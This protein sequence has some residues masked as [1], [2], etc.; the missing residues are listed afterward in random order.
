MKDLPVIYFISDQVINMI[1]TDKYLLN[2]QGKKCFLRKTS[3]NYYVLQ[4]QFSVLEC[5][6]A[7]RVL[8]GVEISILVLEG[9]GGRIIKWFIIGTER[10]GLKNF[11]RSKG[12]NCYC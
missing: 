10:T 8:C 1:K 3:E 7:T 6:A 4:R 2:M 5:N 9:K 11:T 12:W